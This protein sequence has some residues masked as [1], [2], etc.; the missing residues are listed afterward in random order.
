MRMLSQALGGH[1]TYMVGGGAPNQHTNTQARGQSS[2]EQEVRPSGTAS[3][4]PG[5]STSL[6][7]GQ[8]TSLVPGQ[9]TSQVPR[10]EGNENE[11]MKPTET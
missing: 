2:Q 11:E 3:L 4:A 6:V 5:R 9:S 1:V 10:P 8:P 7:P